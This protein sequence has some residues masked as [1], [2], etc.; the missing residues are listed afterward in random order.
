MIAVVIL[1]HDYHT[2]VVV[3]SQTN[4]FLNDLNLVIGNDDFIFRVLDSTRVG[5]DAYYLVVVGGLPVCFDKTEFLCTWSRT[6]LLVA[7]I[8]PCCILARGFWAPSRTTAL[9]TEVSEHVGS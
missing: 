2:V 4:Y 5:W 9:L 1:A 3:R 6:L 8:V 7:R